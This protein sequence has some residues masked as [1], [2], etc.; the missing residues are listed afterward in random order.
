LPDV[1][2]ADARTRET[3]RPDGVVFSFQVIAKT[4]EPSISNR[5]FNLFTKDD[6]RAA[7]ADELIPRRPKIAGIV[8]ASL[9]AGRREGLTG[10]A[11]GP[12][13]AVIRPSGESEREAPSPDAGEEMALSESSNIV[14]C[15]IGNGSFIDF[16]IGYQSC[17]D[18]FAQPGCG[19]RIVFVVVRRHLPLRQAEFPAPQAPQDLPGRPD[20]PVPQTRLA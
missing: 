3:D 11:S 15:D 4:I 5:C 16:A 1:E 14:G 9:G 8:P 17:L 12:D 13:F 6:W 10:A 7:L 2:R 19:K 18:Q 20:P